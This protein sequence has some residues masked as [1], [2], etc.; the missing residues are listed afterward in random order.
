MP[1]RAVAIPKRKGDSYTHLPFKLL[2]AIDL[3]LDA[4]DLELG[5]ID[6]ELEVGPTTSTSRRSECQTTPAAR[7][8]RKPQREGRAWPCGHPARG[9]TDGRTGGRADGRT[10]GP[11]RSA[12]KV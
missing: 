6:L 8:A 11:Q 9:R 2:G 1:L 12:M 7:G 10:G 4:I 5:A 3:E